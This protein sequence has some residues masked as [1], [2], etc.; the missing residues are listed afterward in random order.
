MQG[1]NHPA[2]F[3]EGIRFRNAWHPYQL[4]ILEEFD[5]LVADRFFHVVAAPGSGKT[6]LGL[7]AVRRINKRKR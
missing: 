1:E 5:R 2:S 4:R 6:V 7:E 3:H